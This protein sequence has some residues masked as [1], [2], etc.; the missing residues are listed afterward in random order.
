MP[1]VEQLEET[2]TLFFRLRSYLPLVLVLLVIASLPHLGQPFIS[3]TLNLSWELL[4]IA[5]SLCGLMIR[6]LTIGYAPR[7]TSGRNT[8]RQIADT[9]NTTGMYSLV[10]HPLYLGNFLL[11]LGVS[12]IMVRAWW[13]PLIYSLSFALYYERIILAEEQ[14]LRSKFGEKYLSWA[15]HIP[16]IIPY[17]P[18]WVK[19]ATTFSL[20]QAIRREYQSMF[21]AALSLFLAEQA[22]EQRDYGWFRPDHGWLVATATVILVYVA[23]RIIHKKTDILSGS[24]DPPDSSGI[25]PSSSLEC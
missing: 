4:S 1:L 17:A 16:A 12:L 7:G 6:V 11:G 9:L 5:V 13:I 10:R 20:R 19:P 2:G 14:F 24:V 8:G 3:D 21:G 15:S 23:I 25:A 22:T 18:V